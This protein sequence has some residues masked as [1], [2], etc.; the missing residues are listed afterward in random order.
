[1]RNW[2]VVFAGVWALSFALVM[3]FVVFE[4][5]VNDFD[6]AGG[7]IV[8]VY[9]ALFAIAGFGVGFIAIGLNKG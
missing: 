4:K 8:S 9:F 2:W 6:F 1:V 5:A 3:G 7:I